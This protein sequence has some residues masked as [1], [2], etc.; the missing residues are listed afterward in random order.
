MRPAFAAFLRL[1]GTAFFNRYKARLEDA[2]APRSFTAIAGPD[3][4]SL[5]AA[6]LWTDRLKERTWAALS[7]E[8]GS[9]PSFGALLFHFLRGVFALRVWDQ[10]CKNDV[11]VSNMLQHGYEKGSA[12]EWLLLYDFPERVAQLTA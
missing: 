8:E 7:S 3:T 2:T 12:G 9:L 4:T 5:S 6:M 11:V 10:A 1:V